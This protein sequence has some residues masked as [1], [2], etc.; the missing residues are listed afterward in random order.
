MTL[1]SQFRA[2]RTGVLTAFLIAL[3]AK[4]LSTH[5]AMP[6]MLLALLLG[7]AMN[8]LFEGTA[9]QAGVT[10][11]SKTLLRLAVGLLGVRVSY[12]LLADLGWLYIGVTTAS[13]FGIIF[14]G[15]VLSKLFGQSRELGIL[16]GGSTAI[17]GASA[18][19][20]IAATLPENEKTERQLTAT[21]FSVT[22]LSTVA[23]IAYPVLTNYLGYTD[24]VAG[25]FLGATI[26]DVAQVVG[27]GLSIS[28]EAGDN[29]VLV[30]LFRVSLLAP[31]VLLIS[32]WIRL[33]ARKQARVSQEKKP[34]LV[35][36]FV[37]LF[38]VL[39]VLN[40]LHVIPAIVIEAVTQ[41]SSWGLLAA[42]AA[43]GMKTSF[44]GFWSTGSTVIYMVLIE[45]AV[46]ASI[47]LAAI[48][49]L[50]LG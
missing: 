11:S 12:D 19:V 7:L 48:H 16:T 47:F 27:A 44:R 9:A 29:A 26:H 17:C 15:V 2:Y 37:G 25:A 6:A 8:S 18:A 38:L 49:L 24:D 42:I 32:L 31:V 33:Q 21:V 34:P 10:W 50:G 39:A 35:P 28:Q 3:A 30:K 4:F 36:G 22:A 43:V 45:T 46:L 14:L 23:M 1:V 13:V 40:S 20:A 5:Y 41:L